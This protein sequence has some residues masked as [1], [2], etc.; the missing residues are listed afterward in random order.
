MALPETYS[1]KSR[2]HRCS[3][4]DE[5]FKKGDTFHTAIYPDPE[6]EGYLRKDYSDNAWKNLPADAPKPFSIW[7]SHYEPPIHDEKKQV[8]TKESAEELLTRLVEEDQEHTENARYILAIMLERQ[9]LVKETDTQHTTNGILRIYEHRKTGEIYI[10]RDPN[11]PLSEIETVQQEVSDLLE[12]E[13]NPPQPTPEP[14]SE[15]ESTPET[16]PNSDPEPEPET[17]PPHS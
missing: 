2:S 1:I 4:T 6:T 7:K 5:P 11:I 3:V 15:S 17:T 16:E 13:Q 14:E 10:V 9:K 8:V 12:A